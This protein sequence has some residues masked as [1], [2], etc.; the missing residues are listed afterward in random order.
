M[1]LQFLS[2]G[3]VFCNK[4]YVIDRADAQNG[5]G[6]AELVPVLDKRL[7]EGV[8]GGVVTLAW[9]V[10]ERDKRACHDEKVQRLLHEGMMKIP[11]AFDFRLD[12][13]S[14]LFVGDVED[15]SVLVESVSFG[16]RLKGQVTYSQHHGKMDD[17]FDWPRSLLDSCFDRF[18]V[19]HSAGNR[20]NIA[21]HA[22]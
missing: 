8:R 9:L 20:R 13:S 19:F 14:P 6:H 3:R 7:E 12:C 5:R 15:W 21:A 16:S 4:T 11:C 18:Y 1:G 2:D 17:A 22:F 10:D